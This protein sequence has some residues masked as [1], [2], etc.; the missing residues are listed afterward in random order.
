MAVNESDKNLAAVLAAG[1]GITP[2]ANQVEA[3]L[4]QQKPA[5]AVAE[6][7]AI[8]PTQTGAWIIREGAKQV[9]VVTAADVGE[10]ETKRN[11]KL[12]VRAFERVELLRSILGALHADDDGARWPD[13]IKLIEQEL[14]L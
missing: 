12:I 6:W 5:R 8:G 9:A 4:D 7:T 11:A 2:G 13:L 10:D 1:L 3:L 14:N